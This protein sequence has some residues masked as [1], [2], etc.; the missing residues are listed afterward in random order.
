MILITGATGNVASLL[1]PALREAGEQVRALVHDVSK[2]QTL[3]DLGVEVVIGDMERPETLAKAVAGV[4][5]IYLIT[6]N[7]PASARQA[8]NVIAAAKE[9]GTPKIVRQSAYGTSKSRIIQQHEEIE[10]ELEHSELPYTV[11]KPTFFMQ[12]VMM[13]AQTVAS[14]GAVYA[15]MKDGRLGMIDLRDVAEVAH[16]VLTTGGHDG[17]TYVLTG[18]ASISFHDVARGLSSVLQKEV[19]Y[20]DVPPKAARE[21][22]VG[23]GLPEWIADGFVELFDGFSR[24]FADS[25]TSNVEQLTG[26]PARSFE[27]FARDYA[28]MFGGVSNKA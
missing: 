25:T 20:I 19:S 1:I 18:P 27:T 26:H 12:N 13:A 28:D 5:Q 16:K 22:M 2:A 10:E 17:K 14:D 7:G 3:E 8:K 15:P 6:S 11:V 4:D 24:G 21:A 9:A 23:M